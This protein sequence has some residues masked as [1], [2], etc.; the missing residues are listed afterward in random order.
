MVVVINPVMS[1]V[2]VSVHWK[3]SIQ[4]Y[5]I[6]HKNQ[7]NGRNV[8]YLTVPHNGLKVNGANARPRAAT[9]VRENVKFTVKLSKLMG[10]RKTKL[11][12]V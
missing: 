9:M 6:P 3:L 4:N 12:S 1:L 5:V 10:N 7:P 8:D 11:K 2:L